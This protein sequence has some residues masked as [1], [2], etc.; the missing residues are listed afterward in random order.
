LCHKS[1]EVAAVE[2][3]AI[4]LFRAAVANGSRHACNNLGVCLERRAL[5]DRHNGRSASTRMVLREEACRA[6]KLGASRG[7]P[8]VSHHSLYS[9][10]SRADSVHH[11]RACRMTQSA[12][13]CDQA[14]ANLGYNL[15]REALVVLS[16]S[17][18]SS[19]RMQNHTTAEIVAAAAS[20]THLFYSYR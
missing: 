18:V 1:D 12:A 9:T 14:M 15:A 13:L 10:S 7:C 6:Y 4:R 3:E 16:S 19:R 2:E 20:G 17:A 5:S 11:L 8:Q